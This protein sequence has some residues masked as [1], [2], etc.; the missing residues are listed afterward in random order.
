MFHLGT[1]EAVSEALQ[2]LE[3]TLSLPP[4]HWAVNVREDVFPE[5]FFP[6]FFNYRAYFDRVTDHFMG[7]K[8]A[9]PA[10]ARLVLASMHFYRGFYSPYQGFFLGGLDDFR[11]AHQ[12]DP[13]F[14]YYQLY[15]ADR[16][17][18][19]GL[20]EDQAQAFSLL[21]RLTSDSFLFLHALKVVESYYPVARQGGVAGLRTTTDLLPHP[22][23][24]GGPR[25][26]GR[27]PLP[28]DLAGSALVALQ[29]REAIEFVDSIEVPALRPARGQ[30]AERSTAL[31]VQLYHVPPVRAGGAEAREG[32]E[33][34]QRF[35]QEIEQLRLR[36]SMMETSKFWKMR[37]LWLRMKR[38]VGL[39]GK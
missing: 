27:L 15:L 29:V 1:P 26:R 16:L 8:A 37:K 24:T 3:E 23:G 35:Q 14:P 28:P 22:N 21:T 30:G 13:E 9:G 31:Q 32:N 10:L 19:R 6:Q 7:G 17:L 11:R 34:I 5:D 33:Q 12:L 4:G 18:A 36:I 20:P 2:L 38:L 39:K 25:F